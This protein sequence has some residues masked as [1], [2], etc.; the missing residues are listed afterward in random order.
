[1]LA[2]Q[3]SSGGQHITQEGRTVHFL[4]GKGK[5]VPGSPRGCG[6][7]ALTEEATL[8]PRAHPTSAGF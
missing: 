8:A 2:S 3:R 7:S 1:M 4:W 5:G 6:P